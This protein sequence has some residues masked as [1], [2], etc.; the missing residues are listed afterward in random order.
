[1]DLLLSI[2]IICLILHSWP[3]IT[4]F[5]INTNYTF[6]ICETQFWN[7]KHYFKFPST[8]SCNLFFLSLPPLSVNEMC[9]FLLNNF[10]PFFS[11]ICCQWVRRWPHVVIVPPSLLLTWGPL[12]LKS[13]QHVKKANHPLD[14]DF[15]KFRQKM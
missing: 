4:R 11:F 2:S 14:F 7:W 1:M 5:E 8:Y 15:K 3:C 12:R 9:F 13:C 10:C 6:N